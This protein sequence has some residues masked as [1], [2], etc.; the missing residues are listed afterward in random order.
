MSTV[1]L[2][3]SAPVPQNARAERAPH[4]APSGVPE[5]TAHGGPAGPR[6]T[7]E[8]LRVGILGATGAVGQKL[9]AR[10]AGHPW[11]KVTAV[12]A[13][14]RSVGRRYG[15]AVHWLEAAL[16]PPEIAALT[17]A[18]AAPPLQCDLV[19]S[20]LDADAA[21]EVESA[22]AA[23]G[24]AVF[25]NASA[26]RMRPE[27]PLLVPEVNADHLCLLETQRSA[28]GFVVTNPN[29]STVGLVLALKPLADAFGL[30]A[31]QV[32]TMQA[33]SGAGYPGVPSLDILGNVV[34]H[35]A[36]EE[37][38]LEA[39][40]RKILG[41]L[42]ASG[43]A[44]HPVTISAQANRVPVLDGH[45][46]SIAVRT[47]R[48]AGVDDVRA[49]LAGFVSPLAG[50][51]L[52]SAPARPLELLP[53]GEPPQPRRHAERGGGM[54][55]HVGCV[56]ECPVLGVRLVALVHNTVRGAAGAAILNAELA[57]AKGLVQPHAAGATRKEATLA[58][59][60]W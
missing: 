1:S 36:G 3:T 47:V 52:P 26:H 23:A 37:A 53:D 13:S 5:R 44:M 41:T 55:V 24:Y 11:L 6:A 25:S 42:S 19:I 7:R 34:P 17:V 32:T 58:A 45:L 59:D 20:A 46:L 33:A 39:E 12:A 16:L 4:A 48:P 2:N 40:P 56:R 35:I 51:G 28:P 18:A 38:K 9:I 21:R 27:V 49:A 15:E 8:R 10:L 50:L 54:V 30:D 14:H 57:I 31:V 22:F 43:V 29:C 60:G